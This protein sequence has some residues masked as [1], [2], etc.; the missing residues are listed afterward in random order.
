MI[1]TGKVLAAATFMVPAALV[2]SG[3]LMLAY[4]R[5]CR[6]QCRTHIPRTFGMAILALVWGSQCALA[7]SAAS[8]AP[9]SPPEQH[10]LVILDTSDIESFNRIIDLISELDAEVPQAYPPNAFVTTVNPKVERALRQHAAVHS[11]HTDRV[12]PA[13][14]ARFGGQAEAAA[15]IWNTAFR[16]TPDAGL[17]PSASV[18]AP[19]WGDTDALIPP[20]EEAPGIMRAPRAPSSNQT[21]EFMAGKVVYSV[22]FVEFE[23]RHRKLLAGRCTN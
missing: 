7:D 17:A 13:T 1:S 12:N 21:S 22:V 6:D 2:G 15:N 8:A 20:L 23:R 19:E 5:K 3:G 16:G 4:A 9:S 11:V 18:A 10:A 14:Y